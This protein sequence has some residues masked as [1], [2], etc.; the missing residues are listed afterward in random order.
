IK[1]NAQAEGEVRRMV[2]EGV[3]S[4]QK[5]D[6]PTILREKLQAFVAQKGELTAAA[7]G[8]GAAVSPGRGRAQ[9]A[10]VDR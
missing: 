4:I 8:E 2:I 9:T 6:N 5:G 7:D 1:A 3:L 10:G